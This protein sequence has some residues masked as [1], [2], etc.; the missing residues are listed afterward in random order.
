MAGKPKAERAGPRISVVI[1]AYNEAATVGDIISRIRKIGPDFEIIVVDDG[2]VDDTSKVAVDAGAKVLTAPYNVGN[3]A[4]VRR[5]ILESAGDVVVMMDCDGQHPPEEIPN[6]LCQLDKYEMAIGAR[7]SKG[8]TSDFRKVGNWALIKVAEWI[9]GH[10]ILDLT[11]GFRAMRKDSLMRYLR[12]FPNRYSYPT[13]ITL[14]FL[15]D[16]RFVTYVPMD[17]IQR[18]AHGESNIR[19]MSDFFRFVAIIF[20]ILM[21]FNPK[22]LFVPLSSILMLVSILIGGW[23]YWNTGGVQ[24]AGLGLF[25]S[26]VIVACFGLIADQVAMVQRKL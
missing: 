16:A 22:R 9:S 18:R 10:K 14:A 12:L 6:L 25:M 4:S 8:N 1:P 2:S 15:M 3:G 24:S 7:T 17:S 20:R 5:G 26:S 21:L 19:P 11:S 13:T 23:Q